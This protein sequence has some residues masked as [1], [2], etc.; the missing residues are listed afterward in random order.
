M[1]LARTEAATAELRFTNLAEGQRYLMDEIV[2]SVEARSPGG[3]AALTIDG[4][5]VEGLI[6]GATN[7]HLSRRL[8]LRGMGEH[9]L[10]AELADATGRH[11]TTQVTIVR[12]PTAIE[13]PEERLRM[14]MLGNLWE[15]AGPRLE[16]EAKFIEEEVARALFQR[17]RFDLVSRDLLPRVL[18]EN[19]LRAALGNRAVDPGLKSLLAADVFAVGK[20][21]RTGESMEIIV[22]AVSSESAR[23]LAY[24][25]VAGT[26]ASVED[27]RVLARDLALRLEQEF[28]KVSGEV[29]QVSGSQCF[30]TLAAADRIRADLPCVVYRLGPAIVHPDTGA[31]LGHPVEILARGTIAEVRPQLSRIA[32]APGADA[33]QVNDHVAT[34]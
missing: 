7:L 31:T 10:R 21:R 5:P 19:E 1:A 11:T 20:V 9:V 13:S 32:L 26:A 30:S 16:D 2:V 15:G 6:P 34:R 23:V 28:P 33:V 14:A 18:E 12:A 8:R 22:Q 3:I 24:A 25:D 29:V 17:E 27:L 4:V